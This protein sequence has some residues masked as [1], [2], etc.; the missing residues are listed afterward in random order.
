LTEGEKARALFAVAAVQNGGFQVCGCL[1]FR[2]EAALYGLRVS[3]GPIDTNPEVTNRKIPDDG[4]R[5]KRCKFAFARI[6][7][8]SHSTGL[9]QTALGVSI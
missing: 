4:V 6:D 3:A 2:Y 8:P 1:A 5:K 7:N 9:V